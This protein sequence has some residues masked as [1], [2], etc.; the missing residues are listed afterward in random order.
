MHF[1]SYCHNNSDETKHEKSEH[2]SCVLPERGRGEAVCKES[3]EFIVPGA[4]LKEAYVAMVRGRWRLSQKYIQDARRCDS[5]R[6]FKI[7]SL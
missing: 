2:S 4:V 6:G 5:S 3:H 1:L 7:C